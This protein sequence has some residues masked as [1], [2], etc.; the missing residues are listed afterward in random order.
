MRVRAWV[1]AL[2]AATALAGCAPASAPVASAPT[3]A[4][5]AASAPTPAA[6]PSV[7][8]A[9]ARVAAGIADCPV[10]DAAA[11]PVPGGLPD[12]TLSCLGSDRAVNVAGLRGRPMVINLWAQWCPPCRAEASH[13]R[14]FAARAGDKVLV[15]GVDYDDPQPDWALEFAT[16]AGWRYAHLTDP[17]RSL[18]EPLRLVGIPTTLLVSADGRIVHR[19]TGPV[20]S[21]AELDA[22]VATYL[23]VQG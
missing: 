20:A 2:L 11:R 23:G 3:P 13:L 6:R 14:D 8:L 5:P 19:V 12:V 16:L 21:A 22:L 10:A 18:A 4:A 15:L 7:D 9:A 17:S 1:G